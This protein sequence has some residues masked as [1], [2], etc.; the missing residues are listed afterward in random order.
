MVFK[1]Q[2]LLS[3]VQAGG[4]SIDNAVSQAQSAVNKLK[5]P[6]NIDINGTLA[7]VQSQAQAAVNGAVQNLAGKIQLPSGLDLISYL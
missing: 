6:G 7:G 4:F 3:R 5:T 2:N 1:P